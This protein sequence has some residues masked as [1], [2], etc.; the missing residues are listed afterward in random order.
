M[1]EAVYIADR[2]QNLVYE[3]LVQLYS[4]GFKSLMNGIRLK[5]GD[6]DDSNPPPLL[7]INDEYYVCCQPADNLYIYV[8]CLL[9]ALSGYNTYNP[10]IPFVLIERLV[11]AMGE[12]FGT[13]LAST[14]IDAN[15][16]T[17]TLLVNEMIDDGIPNI[18]DFNRLR[19]SVL[20]KSFLLKILSTSNELAAAATNKSL[21]SLLK[22]SATRVL[23]TEIIPWRRSNVKYTNNEMFVD[24]VEEVSVI[25]KPKRGHKTR[26][27]TQNFDSAF[28]SLSNIT[29]GQRLVPLTGTISGKIDCL[30]HISGV[31]QLQ[32]LLNSASTYIEAPQ[33]HQCIN[34]TNWERSRSLT[35]IPPDG[36]STLMTYLVDLDVLP[37]KT[38]LNMLGPLEF[39]CLLDLGI[40]LNE[41]EVRIIVLKLQAVPKIESIT[42][43]MFAFAPGE[44]DDESGCGNGVSNIKTIRA[45]HGDFSY[46]GN[47][48]GEWTIKNLS[49]GNQPVFR[50]IISTKGGKD[51]YSEGSASSS[52][53]EN[54][55]VD[56]PS[57]KPV[58]PSYYNVSFTYKGQ[59]PSG[60]RVDSLKVISAKGM[61]DSV[62]PYKGVKYITKTGDYTIRLK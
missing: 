47:G 55:E 33:F 25:L 32:I 28:Y 18:T 30:S 11:E 48:R 60:L 56:K 8:L 43:E 22:V 6:F 21:A 57:A 52:T 38:Q 54:S 10:L 61:G 7:T 19:D 45:T 1:F 53:H 24:V 49:T 35:F 37:E 29:P 16:D 17:L 39:D 20:L 46:K 3:Y 9:A 41:F 31:P 44:D 26:S 51:D 23:D 36:L 2:Q 13:P 34:P 4:P 27:T 58:S 5:F 50:G 62:K 14:K 40:H 15:N 42:V 59:V 12:Y